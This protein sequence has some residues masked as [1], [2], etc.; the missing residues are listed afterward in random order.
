[1]TVVRTIGTVFGIVVRSRGLGGNVV[2]GLRSLAGGEI[3]EYT[4]ML[5]EARTHALGR[6][7][8]NARELG[9]NG[10]VAM[11]FDSSEI[12]QIMSEIVACGTAVVL[13][14]TPGNP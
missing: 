14:Q 3:K 9:A 1:M 10:V 6:M 5:T 13:E 7:K 2:A 12:G 11:R 8:A 4:A